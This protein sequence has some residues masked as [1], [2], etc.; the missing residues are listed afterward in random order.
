MLQCVVFLVE[1]GVYL[2]DADVDVGGGLGTIIL[3]SGDLASGDVVVGCFSFNIILYRCFILYAL[4]ERSPYAIRL[5]PLANSSQHPLRVPMHHKP[6]AV[7]LLTQ[8]LA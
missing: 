4:V 5:Y 3:S 1:Q 8:V 2:V 7:V 6:A